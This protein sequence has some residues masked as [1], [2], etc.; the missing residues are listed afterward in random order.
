MRENGPQ[1]RLTLRFC[2]FL[3]RYYGPLPPNKH[4]K[5][6]HAEIVKT[7]GSFLGQCCRQVP[8]FKGATKTDTRW[9]KSRT[10]ARGVKPI[11]KQGVRDCMVF[12]PC[13]TER[14]AT[15]DFTMALLEVMTSDYGN[16]DFTT[17]V[18]KIDLSILPSQQKSKW[19]FP[20]AS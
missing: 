18:H 3:R 10:A 11:T 19:A 17:K 5:R 2:R 16:P 13:T 14:H 6:S 8:P 9:V 1:K 4:L 15:T 7:A 12:K 20:P